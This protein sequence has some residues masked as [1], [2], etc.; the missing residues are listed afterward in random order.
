M[1]PNC[2]RE[3]AGGQSP[4][5]SFP[6][7]PL[8]LEWQAGTCMGGTPGAPPPTSLHPGTARHR[9]SCHPRASAGDPRGWLVICF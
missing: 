9:G 6:S 2:E 8:G 1:S 4:G 5:F 7:R 3:G